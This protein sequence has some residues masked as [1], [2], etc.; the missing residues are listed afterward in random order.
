MRGLTARSRK[1]A[2]VVKAFRAKTRRREDIAPAA[3]PSS[4][5]TVPQAASPGVDGG[6]AARTNSSRLRV[7]ARNKIS[8]PSR[9]R[10]SLVSAVLLALLLPTAAFADTLIDNVNGISVDRDGKVTR[11]TAMTIDEQGRIVA[12]YGRGDN[13]PRADFRENGRGRTVVPGMI[14]SHAHVMALGLGELVLDLSGTRSLDE[15]LSRLAAYAAANPDR[16]W[17]VGR[18]WNQEAWGLGRFPTAAELDAV[19]AD[20]P[21]WLERV[22]GHA[23]WANSIALQTSRVTAAT[24]DPE[25]GR[26]ERI[27]GGRQPAGV[28][29]DAAMELVAANVPP[30]RADDRDLALHEAQELLIEHGVTAVADMGTSIED[31][32]TFR[33]AGD[34]GRLRIRIMAYASSVPE[35]LLIGGSGPTQWL[36]QDRLRMGGIKL[37]LDGA[38]GSR[39]AKLKSAYA[40]DPGNT[41]LWQTDGTALRNNISRAAMEGYQVAIHAIGDAANAEALNAIEELSPD[42]SG[43]RRWRI[44]HAQVVDPADIPRFGQHGIIASMQPVHQTSDRLMAEARLGPERLDGAYA[45]RSIHAAGAPLAFGSDAPVEAPDPF[46]GM[47]VAISREDEKGEP[48]GG[49]HPLETVTREQALAAYTAGAAFAGF[50]EGKFGRLMPGERADF[51]VLDADPLMASPADLRRI[52]VLE[53]WIG[54]EKVYDADGERTER[55]ADAPGR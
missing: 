9:I 48:F 53:T 18:G 41:G 31:W 24:A 17:I 25:G 15:A 3:K 33:R 51:L 4:F 44:E 47:A 13:P 14:D 20:R 8:Q 36:Y 52:R 54:G 12:T 43:D 34:A 40:D 23:G 6:F 5:S 21:V 32:M 28:L 37:Y 7:F 10:A 35:M 22:D 26:V 30:P 29:V 42:Y 39:G 46:A 2:G 1:S 27:A 50:A 55:P 11:F 16:P 38:L 49:W 45:W 19:V